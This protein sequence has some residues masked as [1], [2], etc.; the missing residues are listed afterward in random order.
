ML[1]KISYAVIAIVLLVIVACCMSN[2]SDKINRTHINKRVLSHGGHVISIHRQGVFES[3][4]PFWYKGKGKDI[5]RVTYSID[6]EEK[7][8]WMRTSSFGNDYNWD[9]NK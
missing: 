2:Y 3:K 7:Y 4:G 8:L 5:Y 9:Y 6:G 1:K